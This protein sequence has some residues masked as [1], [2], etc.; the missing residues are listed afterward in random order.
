MSL[1]ALGRRG[2]AGGS[3][4]LHIPRQGWPRSR[5]RQP[6]KQKEI[7]SPEGVC[8]R[9]HGPRG[10]ATA[11]PRTAETKAGSE[12]HGRTWGG[13]GPASDPLPG[14]TGTFVMVNLTQRSTRRPCRLHAL[15]WAGEGGHP[16]AGVWLPWKL[17]Q[18]WVIPHQAAESP[19]CCARRGQQAHGWGGPACRIHGPGSLTGAHGRC[20]VPAS[21]RLKAFVVFQ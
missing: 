11:R 20:H 4:G 3:Q 13:R 8:C 10:S 14:S 15:L 12:G 7:V 6:W 2:R 17:G 9:N 5:R 16:E 19:V 1:W 18:R 21:H